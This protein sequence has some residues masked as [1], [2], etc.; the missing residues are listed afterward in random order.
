[1]K[2]NNRNNP[3]YIEIGQSYNDQVILIKELERIEERIDKLVNI[4]MVQGITT[5]AI[6]VTLVLVLLQ[7]YN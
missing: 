6:L 5:G 3:E 4:M 2:I 1:M 7:S